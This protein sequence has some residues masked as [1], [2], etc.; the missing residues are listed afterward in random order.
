MEKFDVDYDIENDSLFLYLKDKKSNGAIEM[1]N[2]IFDCDNRGDL[3][4]ME[5]LEASEIFKTVLYKMIELSKIKEFRA[6]IVNF[7]NKN[8]I[9]R[10]NIE[11]DSVNERGSIIIPKVIESPAVNY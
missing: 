10:F 6:D 9:I 8:N 1:G 7:R 3:I 11:T 5:V 2:F 4:A